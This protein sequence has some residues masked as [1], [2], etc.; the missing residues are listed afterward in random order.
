MRTMSSDLGA[1]CGRGP[2]DINNVRF[3]PYRLVN[4]KCYDPSDR[5][6]SCAACHNPHQEVVAVDSFYDRT[7]LA[8]HAAGHAAAAKS[9]AK[10]CP[11][12]KENCVTCHMPKLELPGSHYKFTD[13][14]I[15]IVNAKEGYPP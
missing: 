14:R 4:S 11:A 1:D 7:C 6:I 9:R 2:H 15:R 13:H 12:L 8:C 3:Q 5:R 10:S